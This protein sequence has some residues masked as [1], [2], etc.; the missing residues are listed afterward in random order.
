L[1]ESPSQVFPNCL[2][3]FLDALETTAALEF[4]SDYF[5]AM[6][7]ASTGAISIIPDGI[8]W[9]ESAGGGGDSPSSTAKGS[10]YNRAHL[11]KLP[12][13]QA[14]VVS[15]VAAQDFISAQT[16]GCTVLSDSTSVSGY[17]AGGHAALAGAMS[18]KRAGMT[19][20]KT[21]V[22]GAPLD[23]VTQLEHLLSNSFMNGQGAV[24]SRTNTILRIMVGLWG[25]AY[26][27]TDFDFLANAY[28]N[29]PLISQAQTESIVDGMSAPNPISRDEFFKRVP[30]N[31]LSLLNSDIVD[32]FD[33]RRFVIEW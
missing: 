24:V 6:V 12:S 23:L 10:S 26:S 3:Q 25:F 11:S 7:L 19:I 16:G 1:D 5:P 9:G 21:T 15:Y 32:L 30:L 29:Q 22:G 33:V 13:A 27:A 17:G 20:V 31:P 4:F 2:D 18:L 8:G 28:Q 14:F